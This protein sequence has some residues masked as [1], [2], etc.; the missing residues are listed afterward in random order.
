MPQSHCAQDSC[1]QQDPWIR[2]LGKGPAVTQAEIQGEGAG[3][4][5]FEPRMSTLPTVLGAVCQARPPSTLPWGQGSLRTWQLLQGT[6][7]PLCGHR[8]PFSPVTESNCL[9]ARPLP[10]HRPASPGTQVW[11]A[12]S[13]GKG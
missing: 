12:W 4:V 1:S 13:L 3:E 8:P 11:G 7:A 9:S 10:L 5:T 2:P 6:P